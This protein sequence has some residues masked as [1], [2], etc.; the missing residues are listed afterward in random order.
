MFD[1]LD[2]YVVWYDFLLTNVQQLEYKHMGTTP[3][4]KK[5]TKPNNTKQKTA[6][7]NTSNTDY[8]YLSATFKEERKWDHSYFQNS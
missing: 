2:F 8:Q 4:K 5:E 3:P 6:T 1:Q 7:S